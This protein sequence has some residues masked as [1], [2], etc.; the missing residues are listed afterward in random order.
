MAGR[1]NPN[2]HILSTDAPVYV[3]NVKRIPIVL[4]A[5]WSIAALAKDARDPAPLHGICDE[6]Y[7]VRLAL[8][9]MG[10]SGNNSAARQIFPRFGPKVKTGI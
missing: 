3:C 7:D 10:R 9:D 4:A 5:I 2:F 8:T 1:S 6:H